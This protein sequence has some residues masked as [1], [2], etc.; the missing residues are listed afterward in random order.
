MEIIIGNNKEVEEF[1]EKENE[2]IGIKGRKMEG[3][4]DGNNYC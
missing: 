3:I 1:T 2:G 4:N